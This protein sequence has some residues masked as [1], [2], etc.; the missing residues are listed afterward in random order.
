M[1]NMAYCRFHN[2]LKDLQDCYDHIWD[3]DLGDAESKAKER[4]IE[5]CKNIAAE[6][7][8]ENI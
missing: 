5:V 4:L 8:Y 1:G 7:K 3:D 2:T 6:F